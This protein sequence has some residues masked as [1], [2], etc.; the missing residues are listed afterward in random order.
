MK[1]SNDENYD[2]VTNNIVT[3]PQGPYK[4]KLTYQGIECKIQV[5]HLTESEMD[6]RVKTNKKMTEEKLSGLKE[7][8]EAEGFIVQALRHNLFW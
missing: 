3:N 7:Y 1:S 6:I 5:K 2:D 8:L 4:V